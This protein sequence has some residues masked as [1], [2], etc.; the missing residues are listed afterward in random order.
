MSRDDIMLT[1]QGKLD[2][3]VVDELLHF[4]ETILYEQGIEKNLRKKIFVILVETLQNSLKHQLD[5]ER[6][7]D[8][9]GGVSA[10]AAS[11]CLDGVSRLAS[12]CGWLDDSFDAFSLKSFY[13][14]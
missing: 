4:S 7:I 14:F 1:Y 3:T 10:D 11:D 2:E 13:I 5:L 8:D 6:E 9:L 12:L